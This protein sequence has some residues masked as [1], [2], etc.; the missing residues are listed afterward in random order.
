MS[1]DRFLTV[2]PIALTTSGSVGCAMT[3]RAS[4][5]YAPAW[6]PEPQ[7]IGHGCNPLRRHGNFLRRHE[8]TGPDLLQTDHDYLVARRQPFGDDAP[9]VVQCPELDPTG[10]DLVLLV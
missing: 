6:R 7:S 8:H 9:A 4:I 3:K 5:F 2:T 1:G 10:D